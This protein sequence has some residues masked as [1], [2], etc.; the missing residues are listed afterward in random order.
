MESVSQ[1]LAGRTAVRHLPLLELAE[2]EGRIRSG[3]VTGA[4]LFSNKSSSTDPWETLAVAARHQ[5]HSI[6]A[7]S[8]LPEF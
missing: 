5:L 2:M 7:G 8:Q 6:P 1:S 3:Q 4:G